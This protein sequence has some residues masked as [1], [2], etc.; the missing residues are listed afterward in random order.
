MAYSK[1]KTLEE[2]WKGYKLAYNLFVEEKENAKYYHYANFSSEKTRAK[3]FYTKLCAEKDT[4]KEYLDFIIKSYKSLKEDVSSYSEKAENCKREMYNA[5]TS[6]N[7]AGSIKKLE[8]NVASDSSIS[9]IIDLLSEIHVS[10]TSFKYTCDDKISRSALLNN[11]CI[12]L[13]EGMDSII[14]YWSNYEGELRATTYNKYA[15][16]VKTGERVISFPEFWN[17]C[18]DYGF[19]WWIN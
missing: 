14:T 19:N 18:V 3:N 6:Y 12:T 1:L 10:L 8:E 16:S 2:K 5:E 11:L 9:K 7:D 17:N 13:C 4:D 15:S